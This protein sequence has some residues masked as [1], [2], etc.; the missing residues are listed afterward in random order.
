MSQHDDQVRIRHMVDAARKAV[1]YASD[2]SRRGLDDD[3]L[4]ALAL[5]RLLE[6]VGEAAKAVSQPTRAQFPG[7]P[8]KAIAGTRD[9]LIHGY[10]DVDLDIVWQIVSEDLPTLIAQLEASAA[11]ETGAS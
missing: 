2:R 6:I 1:G 3:E 5:T 11:D 4:L 8:W 10:F 9:R 7:V